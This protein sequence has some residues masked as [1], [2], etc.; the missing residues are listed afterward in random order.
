[1]SNFL[2]LRNEIINISMQKILL[3]LFLLLLNIYANGQSI[4]SYENLINRQELTDV[5]EYLSDDLTQGRAS[6]TYGKQSAEQYIVGRFKEYGLKPYNWNYTQSFSYNDSIALRNVVGIIPSVEKS[7]EF[8][9]IGA[10]YDHL[11][12]LAG[13]IY[14]GADDNAS[15]VAALLSIAKSFAKMKAEGVGPKKN[16]MF[17]AY[18]GKELSLAGSHFFTENLSIP[19]KKVFCAINIDM[20]GTTLAPIHKGRN[21]YLIVLGESSLP[22]SLQGEIGNIN[23]N[24]RFGMDI[25]YSF[26]GSKDFTQMMYENGDHYSFAQKGIPSLLFTSAFHN[27]TYKPSDTI[28]IIDF[29]ILRKR[30]A[31]L[32]DV[33]NKFSK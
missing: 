26:Y 20:L 1:M 32:F 15:G 9:I 25:D 11:G 22:L 17:V 23:L 18:D 4:I 27:Y 2:I 33:I 13:R 14:H 31:F 21:D 6:G 28:D 30:T 8:V 3:P 19:T 5:V 10:H 29:E 12:E 16:L 7:D 24:H